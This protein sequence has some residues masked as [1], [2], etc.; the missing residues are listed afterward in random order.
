MKSIRMWV[1]LGCA[2]LLL[3]GAG[4][5]AEKKAEK[6]TC[7]QEAAAQDKECRHRCCVAAHKEGKSCTK[8]NP[9]KED[10]KTKKDSKKA[11]A[12]TEK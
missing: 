8:C 12:A 7:C 1:G 5:G 6:L 4:F 2:L 3:A 9:N 11:P 10:L